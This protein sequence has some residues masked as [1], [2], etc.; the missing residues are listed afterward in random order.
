MQIVEPDSG[1]GE[2]IVLGAFSVL[3]QAIYFDWYN[4]FGEKFIL[5]LPLRSYPR[6]AEQ[7]RKVGTCRATD[8]PTAC[9]STHSTAFVWLNLGDCKIDTFIGT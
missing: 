5:I 6:V 8:K 7:T 2:I 3:F 1:D 4:P 9:F